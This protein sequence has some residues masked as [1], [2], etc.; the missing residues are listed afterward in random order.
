MT[1]TDAETMFRIADIDYKL[2]GSCKHCLPDQCYCFNSTA[3]DISQIKSYLIKRSQPDM[4]G[5]TQTISEVLLESY[6][7]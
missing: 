3:W 5:Q 6:Y 7:L 2:F 1:L 4:A